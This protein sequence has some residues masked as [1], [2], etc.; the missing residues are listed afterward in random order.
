MVDEERDVVATRAERR[1]RHRDDVQTVIEVFPEPPR[2]DLREQIPV[3]RRYHTHVGARRLAAERLVDD[4]GHH[5]VTLRRLAHSLGVGLQMPARHP[6]NPL[7]LL[8][9]PKHVILISVESLS[10]SFLGIHGN[11]KGLTPRMD[12]LA[13]EG[14]QFTHLFAT[15]T[16]TVRGLE[17]LEEEVERRREISGGKRSFILVPGIDVPFPQRELRVVHQNAPTPVEQ[18]GAAAD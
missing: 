18:L 10:A 12:A 8:R 13:K 9:R 17:A 11:P 15:G 1:R 7:P 5:E 4:E 6:F 3:G 16:R 2:V 14:L